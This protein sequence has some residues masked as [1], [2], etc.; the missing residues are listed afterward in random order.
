[1]KKTDFLV[2][3]TVKLKGF[4]EEDVKKSLEFY[5][6]MIDERIEDGMPEEEAVAAV[7]SVDEIVSQIT[8]NTP[9]VQL[10]KQKLT[11]NRKLTA[12][13]KALLICGSPLWLVLIIAALACVFAL[14][15]S[16]WAGVVVLYAIPVCFGVGGVGGLIYSVFVG[17][18]STWGSGLAFAG[19]SL[20]L[21]GLALPAYY[22]CKFT[23]KALIKLGVF[24][25]QCIKKAFAKK[26]V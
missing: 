14:Y 8:A 16:L 18:G 7:G 21:I 4:P 12:G 25:W 5:G 9:M 17:I 24:F 10:L 22:V 11:L 3:L 1:M 13:E 15:V 26:G 20:I 23:A 19:A 2:A 6:E